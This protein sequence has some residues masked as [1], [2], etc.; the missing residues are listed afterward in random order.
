M[1]EILL[2][3]HA[4]ASFTGA[5]YDRLSERGIAQAGALGRWLALTGRGPGAIVTGTLRRH[6]DTA[7]EMLSALPESLRGAADP[8]ADPE[9][10]EFDVLDVLGRQRAEFASSDG[11]ARFIAASPDP[12]RHFQTVFDAAVSRWMEDGEDGPYRE[13]WP[14]F[15]RRC[16]A[17]FNRLAQSGARSGHRIT[18]I[19]SGGPIAVI[20]QALLGLNDHHAAALNATLINA[21]ITRIGV[22]GVHT[23]LITLNATGHLEYTGDPAM[24]T[25]R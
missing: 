17:G 10:D 24:I 1:G 5:E 7:R 20:C 12:A 6:R 13:S 8:A 2:I 21:A 19:T 16:L 22:S 15:R 14:A 4:Q 9:F 23:S 18:V 11:I 3:R 25:R